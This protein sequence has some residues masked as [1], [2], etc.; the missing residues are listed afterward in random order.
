MFIPRR[1]AVLEKTLRNVLALS[2]KIMGE[3]PKRSQ[4]LIKEDATE[5]VVFWEKLCNRKASHVA[6]GYEKVTIALEVNF[7]SGGVDL[8]KEDAHRCVHGK[9]DQE[10]R[11]CIRWNVWELSRWPPIGF[12]QNVIKIMLNKGKGMI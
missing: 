9:T 11:W 1:A 12:T 10:K 4:F 7:D 6:G 8:N 2:T 3:N 5:T